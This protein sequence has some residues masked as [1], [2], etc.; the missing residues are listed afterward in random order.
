MFNYSCCRSPI[1]SDIIN[2][3]DVLR[4]QIQ[5]DKQRE[6]ASF[7]E[8]TK[9]Q[10]CR[11][12]QVIK[13]NDLMGP[14]ATDE[15]SRLLEA[16]SVWCVNIEPLLWWSSISSKFLNISDLAWEVLSVPFSSGHG[17]SVFRPQVHSSIPVVL[18]DQMNL[19]HLRYYCCHERRYA[20]KM[21]VCNCFVNFFLFHNYIL[22]STRFLRHG[23]KILFS[24]LVFTIT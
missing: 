23:Q 2:D 14:T 12:S 15:I 9:K 5:V 20:S 10:N 21:S 24:T 1:L 19:F 7:G 11:L 8:K 16:T 17:E 22:P 6:N 3:A 13:E 18:V 4:Q